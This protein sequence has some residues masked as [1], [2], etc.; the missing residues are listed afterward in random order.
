MRYKCWYEKLE[1]PHFCTK[2]S[3]VLSLIFFPFFCPPVGVESVSERANST[4]LF[5]PGPISDTLPTPVFHPRFSYHSYPRF[6]YHS[7]PRFSYATYPR[8]SCHSYPRFSYTSYPS[9][10]YTPRFSYPPP[11]P[12]P[13][14]I[15]T[16]PRFRQPYPEIARP[17]PQY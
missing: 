7:H 15:S 5:K 17:C 4:L 12:S 13:P 10:S 2:I 8:F 16:R 9:F 3:P 14:A 11:F 1:F 6:S